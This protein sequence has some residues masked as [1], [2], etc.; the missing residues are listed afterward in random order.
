MNYAMK[1][2]IKQV[3]KDNNLKPF[4]T[5]E[6]FEDAKIKKTLDKLEKLGL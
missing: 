5:K 4:K 3:M 2:R 6:E 1:E